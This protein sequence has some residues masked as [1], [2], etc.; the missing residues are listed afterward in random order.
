MEPPK[1]VFLCWSVDGRLFFAQ[2]DAPTSHS[3]DTAIWSYKAKVFL[4]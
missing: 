3:S 1:K 4:N 2:R